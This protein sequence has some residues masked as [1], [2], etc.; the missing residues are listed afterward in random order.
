M[1]TRCAALAALLALA[2][3]PAAASA[4]V[5]NSE[6]VFNQQTFNQ[7][8]GAGNEIG[9]ETG[10]TVSRSYNTA[11][12][13]FDP[14]FPTAE[15]NRSGCGGGSTYAFGSRTAWV[16]FVPA[17]KGRL[18]VSA[19]TAYNVILYAYDTPLARGAKGFSDAELRTINCNDASAGGGEINMPVPSSE[20]TPGK[21]ILLETASFCGY[22][23]PSPCTGNEPGGPTTLTV[24]FVP[25]DFDGDSV[26][27]T[28]DKCTAKGEAPSGCPPPDTDGDGVPDRSDVCLQDP[29]VPPTG[30]PADADG[31]GV[32]NENDQCIFQ[33][34]TNPGGCPDPDGDG[35]ANLADRCPTVKGI[36]RDG[37]PDGDRDG[38]SNRVDRCKSQRGTDPDGCPK[39]LGARFPDLWRVFPASTQVLKLQVKA[40]KGS[41]VR[42]RCKGRGCKVRRA[43]FKQR[44]ATH[45][46][47]RYLP[48]SRMLPVGTV[49]EIRVTAPRTLGTFLRL[50]IR[51]SALPTRLDRCIA[52]S[53]KLRKCPT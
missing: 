1:P 6:D 37:C 41:M 12:Y 7:T 18:T 25:D 2:V 19:S 44:R 21:A 33:F 42:L 45:N 50:R 26:P 22:G 35:V 40:P 11:A 32:A 30:C 16:R 31:D 36:A 43:H 5:S 49:L 34:G 28:R 14:D 23:P 38:V 4:E 17:V 10:T 51:G 46:L 20:V 48:R 8:D 29:G 9:F 13:T 27:D 3:F 24:E 47:R 39:P 15:R 52:S 53:G